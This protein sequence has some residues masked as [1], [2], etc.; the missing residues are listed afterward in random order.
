MA[1][2]I[3]DGVLIEYAEEANVTDVTIPESVTVIGSGA[4]HN[5]ETITNVM[6]PDTVKKIESS[7]RCDGLNFNYLYGRLRNIKCQKGR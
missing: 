1:F 7:C 5:C 6:I 3:E 2:K 4:F